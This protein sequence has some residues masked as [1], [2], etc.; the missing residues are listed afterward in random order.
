MCLSLTLSGCHRSEDYSLFSC[1]PLNSST[2]A[3]WSFDVRTLDVAFL[4]AECF[5][6][7]DLLL[8]AIPTWS[9]APFCLHE[10]NSVMPPLP[11]GSLAWAR[12]SCIFLADIRHARL[13]VSCALK[14]EKVRDRNPR[15][16]K[17]NQG[18]EPEDRE[19][20]TDRDRNRRTEFKNEKKTARDRNPRTG[21]NSPK[22][23]T[24]LA[25]VLSLN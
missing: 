10:G 19:K 1:K 5:G 13:R 18:P 11:V 9:G 16:E 3:Y 24:F 14:K 12:R 23:K 4:R 20:K 15:T 7:V 17:K 25:V 21:K 8:R 6:C 22:I 2:R